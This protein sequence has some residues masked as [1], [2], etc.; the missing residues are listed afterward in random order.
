M[1][2][3]LWVAMAMMFLLCVLIIG[4]FA[5]E[6]GSESVTVYVTIS[7]ETGM[8]VLSQEAIS[9][10]DSDSDGVLS[11]N[12]ALYVS[13]EVCY[14]GGAAE[15]YASSEGQYGLC[16][17]KLWGA[18]NGG[19]YGYYVNNAPAWSLVGPVKDGDY[20][21]AFI[22]TDLIAWS[23]TYCYFDVNTALAD[24]NGDVTLTLSAQGYDESYNPIVIPVEGAVITIDGEATE[25]VTDAEGKA[26]IA[27]RESGTHIISA[28]SEAQTL[29]PPVCKV[30]FT[31]SEQSPV[32]TESDGESDTFALIDTASDAGGEEPEE[33]NTAFTVV[34]VAAVLVLAILVFCVIKRRR[35]NEE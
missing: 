6:A 2:K 15:G 14:E 35:T 28:T 27:L 13:H 1:K 7:D 29:V 31:Q 17:D 9:V 12:D 19:S 16:M 32:Q 5:A 21:N 18:S 25:Y 33:N 8:L 23:D 20:V 11:I 34:I 26:K 22:Y 30:T 10:T 3:V 4:V 24:E